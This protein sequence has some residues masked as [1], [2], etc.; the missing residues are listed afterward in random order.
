M[1]CFLIVITT[2]GVSFFFISVDVYTI[3]SVKA[4]LHMCTYIYIVFFLL[5]SNQHYY[6]KQTPVEM[7]PSNASPGWQRRK[8][9]TVQFRQWFAKLNN[10]DLKTKKKY[11]IKNTINLDAHKKYIYH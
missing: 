9:A 6:I 8:N 7:G 4:Y 2:N 1:F 5:F 10:I 11:Y 3:M